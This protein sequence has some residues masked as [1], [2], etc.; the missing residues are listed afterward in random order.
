MKPNADPKELCLKLLKRSRC[1]V[2]VSAVL[3]TKGIV[4]ATGW[5]HEGSS[6]FGE[7]AE[8]HC[9]KRANHK[10]I[11]KSVLYVAAQRKKSGN[12]VIAKPCAFCWAFAKNCAYVVYRNKHGEWVTMRGENW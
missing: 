9:F 12:P 5:N 8:E 1:A 7:H 3:T 6:G 10:D 4:T 2:Q 11:P